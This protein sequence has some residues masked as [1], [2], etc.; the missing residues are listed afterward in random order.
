MAGGLSGRGGGVVV[1]EPRYGPQLPE[2]GD[3]LYDSSRWHLISYPRLSDAD[4]ASKV[5]RKFQIEADIKPQ[6]FTVP[7]AFRNE[8]QGGSKT[9]ARGPVFG[10]ITASN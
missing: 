5:A 6:C 9:G 3:T 2:R 7:I 1:I 8:R 10:P 4:A